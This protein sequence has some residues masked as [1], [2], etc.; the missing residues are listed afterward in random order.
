M[1]VNIIKDF[2]GFTALTPQWNELLQASSADCPFLTAEW[3]QA[4]WA[5]AAT[6]LLV[7]ALG[8]AYRGRDWITATG[9]LA[10]AAVGVHLN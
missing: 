7:V 10:R 8:L 2:E 1:T 6:V 9:A 5:L 4:W 3:L